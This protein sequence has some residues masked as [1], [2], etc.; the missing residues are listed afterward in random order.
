M[1]YRIEV[2]RA[3]GVQPKHIVGAIAN[4]AGID[5]KNIGQIKLYDD[6]STIDLPEGMSKELLRDLHKVWVCGQQLKMSVASGNEMGEERSSKPRS[7]PTPRSRRLSSERSS[8]RSSDRPSSSKPR[9]T[10]PRSP[11]KRS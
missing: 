4:E 7:S 10:S 9:T 1:R 2:G 11:K 5:S 3:H 8:D 6:F